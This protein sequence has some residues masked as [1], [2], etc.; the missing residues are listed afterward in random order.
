MEPEVIGE[1]KDFVSGWIDKAGADG[2]GIDYQVRASST[3]LHFSLFLQVACKGI[4]DSMDR[5]FGPFW[6]CVMGEGFS[7]EV[8]RQAKSTLYMY[9]AG[10]V[11]VLLFKC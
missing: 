4:K 11:A 8:T 10:K 3:V 9:Y 7:F 5:Q 2:S 1:A 6:H